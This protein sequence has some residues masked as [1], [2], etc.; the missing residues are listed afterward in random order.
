LWKETS[1]EEFLEHPTCP[2]DKKGIKAI[3]EY[4]EDYGSIECTK[5]SDDEKENERKADMMSEQL[6]NYF[7]RSEEV[8]EQIARDL[9]VE[10]KELLRINLRNVGI[11]INQHLKN[12]GPISRNF[13]YENFVCEAGTLTDKGIYD[14]SIPSMREI[15]YLADLKYSANFADALGIQTLSPRELPPRLMLH[16]LDLDLKDN[17]EGYPLD[18]EV[19]LEHAIHI[20]LSPAYWL[21]SLDYLTLGDIL[22][23]RQ[24]DEYAAF[25]DSIKSIQSPEKI[26]EETGKTEPVD[27][28]TFQES[29]RTY[30]QVIANTCT[31]RRTCQVQPWVKLI[32]EIGENLIDIGLDD[33]CVYVADEM[34]GITD[35]I[36]SV[37]VTAVISS[38]VNNDLEFSFNLLGN[39]IQNAQEQY[40]YLIEMLKKKGFEII[41]RSQKKEI[42]K[43]EGNI[44]DSEYE[45][46]YK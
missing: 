25:I 7:T 2:I 31:I 14:F 18:L 39:H 5:L 9:S 40:A 13:L 26:L 22:A 17:P 36:T 33:Y 32:V 43:E 23:I 24:M 4:I 21:G 15:K 11:K 41:N 1:I 10:D 29:F 45:E 46:V 42:S 27:L 19:L 34:L 28:R 30:Q 35:R 6:A 38:S 12:E 44:T 20:F 8:C 16:E 37:A 3:M